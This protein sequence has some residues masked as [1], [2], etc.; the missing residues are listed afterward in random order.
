MILL[1]DTNKRVILSA[2]K[3]GISTL[4]NSAKGF[5][6]RSGD[7]DYDKYNLDP[8]KLNGK[9]DSSYWKDYD[10]TLVIRNPW[11]RYVSGIRSLWRPRVGP[12]QKFYKNSKYWKNDY[13]RRYGDIRSIMNSSLKK[14]WEKHFKGDFAINN[15]GHISNWLDKTLQLQYKSL[16]VV[17]TQQLYDWQE[18]NGFSKTKD[19]VSGTKE[20]RCIHEF[21]Y[22]NQREGLQNYLKQETDIYNQLVNSEFAFK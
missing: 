7:N 20:T 4:R 9:Y 14:W 18:R 11:E 12:M 22:N 21:L 13:P 19:H 16:E 8:Y 15:D 17:D 5:K 3:C 2:R 10:V 6:D 1:D